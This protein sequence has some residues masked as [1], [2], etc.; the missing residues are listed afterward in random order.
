M[1]FLDEVPQDWSRPELQALQNLFASA[2]PDHR[3]A[4][5]FTATA[6]LREEDFPECRNMRLTWRE[7]FG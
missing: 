3:V 4:E 7:R 2:Y 1:N 5:H 6:G